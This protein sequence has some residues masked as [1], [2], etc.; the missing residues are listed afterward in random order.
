MYL[1]TAPGRGTAP[2]RRASGVS[3]DQ[4]RAQQ[5]AE[6]LLRTGQAATAYIECAY[7]AMT[8]ATLNS[9]YVRTGAGWWAQLSQAGQVVWTPFT[10]P[11]GARRE[12]GQ[13]ADLAG[14][15][16]LDAPVGCCG[17]EFAAGGARG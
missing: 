3:D 4:S 10:A 8:A 2:F 15:R 7:T 13:P 6:L 5:A 12:S 16:T 14:G 1:W 9:C 11:V 17:G